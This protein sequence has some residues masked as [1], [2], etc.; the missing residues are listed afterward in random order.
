MN[1]KNYLLISLSICLIFILAPFSLAKGDRNGVSICGKNFDCNSFEDFV[2]PGKY[3]D[4]SGKLAG[5]D[6]C[7][8]DDYDCCVYYNQTVDVNNKTLFW[9]G[10]NVQNACCGN[11]ASEFPMT[12]KA[13]NS[14]TLDSSNSYACCIAASSCV[15]D[16]VCY[17]ALATQKTCK[18]S[19]LSCKDINDDGNLEACI[20]TN[21]GVWQVIDSDVNCKAY[22]GKTFNYINGK[23]A[24]IVKVTI[25]VQQES[26][27]GKKDDLAS[28]N[29]VVVIT[30]L[31]P[32]VVYKMQKTADNNGKVVFDDIP[33]GVKMIVQASQSKYGIA[34]EAQTFSGDTSL[35]LHLELI[36]ECQPDCTKNDGIC[37]KECIGVCSPDASLFANAEGKG[38]YLCDNAKAGWSIPI[39]GATKKEDKVGFCCTEQAK[40][41]NATQLVVKTGKAENLQTY[42]KIIILPDGTPGTMYITLWEDA[43]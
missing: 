36:N 8:I 16:G 28:S 20:P 14:A 40:A 34:T 35:T 33:V 11:S 26:K 37:H 15:D 31:D 3:T 23:C 4:G 9:D 6:A 17:P 24:G 25:T 22:I 38:K 10:K 18:D 29:S 5:A 1:K 43:Y 27:K 30:S 42:S 39:K 7:A 2:C 41:N 21:N 32:T 12:E 13:S 19:P